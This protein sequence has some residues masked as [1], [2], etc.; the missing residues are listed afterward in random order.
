M[1]QQH[2]PL[3]AAGAVEKHTPMMQQ[4]LRLKVEHPDALLFYRMGDF[5]ELFYDDARQAAQLLGITLTSRGQSAGEPIPMAGVPHHAA[6]GYLAKLTRLGLSVAICEQIGD[7]ASSKGPVERKV[8][9]VVTPGT[10]SDE[11]LLESDRENLLVAIS[12]DGQRF[13]IASLELSSGRFRLC[14]P[15]SPTALIEELGRLQPAELL[16]DE[17]LSLTLP[18]PYQ[19]LL[20]QRPN[21]EFD[22]DSAQAALTRQFR[23]RS[24]AGFGCEGLRLAIGAAGALL[25]YARATQRSELPHLERL[26]VEHRDDSVL[27]DSAT[28]RN[29]EIDRNLAGGR[30][31][32]LLSVL[33]R[34]ATPMGSRLL[35]RWL[36]RPLRD[37]QQLGHRHLA[38][39]QL[40]DGRRHEE[41][42]ALLRRVDDLERIL[43]RV[44]LRSARPRDLTR[45]GQA[46][47]LLPDLHRLL[48]GVD[49]PR[50]LAL[51]AAVGLFPELVELLEAALLPEPP[52]LLRDGGVIAPGFSAELDQ[53]RAMGQDAGAFLMQIEL[54]ER[55]RT[56]L[57]SLKVRYNRV[58]GY[59]IEISRSQADLAP[60]EYQ[61]RQSVKHAERFMIPELKQFEEQALSSQ[62]RA[63]ALEKMLYEGLLDSLNLSLGP[64][65]A[66]AE[67]LAELDLLANLA[68]RAHTLGYQRPQFCAQPRI[69]IRQGRHPV[70]EQVSSD[71]FIANDLELD[72]Q[73]RMLIITGPNMGG[74]STYMRQNALIALLA[75][76]G[77]FVPARSAIL[78]PIDRIFTRIGSADDLAGGR[79]TFMVEMSETANIL[80]HATAN[81]LVLMDEIGRGTSTFDGLALAW[82]SARHLA[83]R[84]G[85]LTL[86]ATHYF[87]LTALAEQ[88]PAVANVHLAATEYGERIVFLHGVREGAASQSYGIHVARLAGLPGAV[89][90]DA[91]ARLMQLEALSRGAQVAS[92]EPPL[93]GDLFAPVDLAHSVLK[94]LQAVDPDRMTP[95][96]AL[97]WLYQLK[98]LTET[99]R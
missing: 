87:E 53:L 66:S 18:K 73:R 59:Y 77:S 67:A 54:R 9:R 23:T 21:W 10:I 26:E 68:E 57:S 85:A 33:D 45:L 47:R 19:P 15:E 96:Q 30:S 5:Y 14:E 2:S 22:H 81:S 63:L 8:V 25:H 91:E 88:L 34:T 70:V 75:Y 83:E 36:H 51:D 74:K 69:E 52:V 13:G 50:L 11:A 72:G 32:T 20:R 6:E 60:P 39:E 49:A 98:A 93:Q 17:S 92:A 79:S 37:Q 86:F 41:I 38:I 64:L 97:E 61:R 3:P 35:S 80:H 56:G 62:S 12:G 46:L 65:R 40:I 99:S 16:I 78:G 71:P 29:L 89:I 4:Y 43:G 7:P 90:T 55:E 44:A 58:H 42:H 24:L 1:K 82:A 28:R 31:N 94:Q 76:S 27:L 95:R 48:H 84:A